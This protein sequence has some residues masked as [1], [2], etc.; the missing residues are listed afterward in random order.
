MK[1]LT[2]MEF[3]KQ[4]GERITD[5]VR[6][7]DSFLITKQGKPVAILAPPQLL[8]D[9]DE[10]ECVIRSDGSFSGGVPLTFRRNLGE[11]GY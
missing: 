7:G 6:N 5:I 10:R 2:M 3:R 1:K 8:K 9:L 4:P 11:G